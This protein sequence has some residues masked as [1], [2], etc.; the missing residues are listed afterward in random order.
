MRDL[1]SKSIDELE[2]LFEQVAGDRI[3]LR[4]LLDELTHRSARRAR[5]LQ[6]R[7]QLA[8]AA[9]RDASA[10]ERA[11]LTIAP[12]AVG[13]LFPRH[14][15]AHSAD[16]TGEKTAPAP[17]AGKARDSSPGATTASRKPARSYPSAAESCAALGVD[18]Q[19]SWASIE[20][21]RRKKVDMLA[22]VA[23]D[24]HGDRAAA[25]CGRLND[26]Y[27]ALWHAKFPHLTEPS[28]P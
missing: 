22:P 9:A 12:P 13:D 14:A 23:E 20:A 7:V 3:R 24:A 18:L 19:M 27:I 17:P 4:E 1:G 15:D 10:G 2:L 11:A 28:L 25:A 21:A 26:A 8:L 16:S 5:A 6:G